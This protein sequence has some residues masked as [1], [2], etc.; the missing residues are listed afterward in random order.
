MLNPVEALSSRDLAERD[1]ELAV[2]EEMRKTLIDCAGSGSQMWKL[3]PGFRSLPNVATM[4]AADALALQKKIEHIIRNKRARLRR[5]ETEGRLDDPATLSLPT[6]IDRAR[7]VRESEQES[8]LTSHLDIEQL[9]AELE[10]AAKDLKNKPDE[11]DDQ[12]EDVESGYVL[13][14]T[15]IIDLE[16]IMEEDE[17][18]EAAERSLEGSQPS[19]AV[20]GPEGSEA[21]S[22]SATQAPGVITDSEHTPSAPAPTPFSKRDSFLLKIGFLEK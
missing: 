22:G 14:A 20:S 3:A 12:N 10:R 1:P 9:K 13:Q 18:L 16:R 7:R 11:F 6:S 17:V 5:V 19:D 4:T 15:A 21:A 8:S 2:Y